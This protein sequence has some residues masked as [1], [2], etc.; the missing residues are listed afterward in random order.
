MNDKEIVHKIRYFEKKVLKKMYELAEDPD[1]DND[2]LSI[3]IHDLAILEKI[4]QK[5]YERPKRV[6]VSV[7]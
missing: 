6:F 1:P 3:N 2:E 4:F 5:N 7:R